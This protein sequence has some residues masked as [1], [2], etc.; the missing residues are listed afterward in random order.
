M[1]K[2]IG[3]MERF[4]WTITSKRNLRIPKDTR[5]L[6][7]FNDNQYSISCFSQMVSKTK[8]INMLLKIRNDVGLLA[9]YVG[10]NKVASRYNV[11]RGFV[12]YWKKKIKTPSFHSG[13]L[14]GARNYKFSADL[15]IAIENLIWS[16]VSND[17]TN[18]IL[19]YVFRIKHLLRVT[20][21][22]NYVERIFRKWRWSWKILDVRKME[23]YSQVYYSYPLC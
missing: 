1:R 10:V 15:R 4:N 7:P 23:K 16:E 5:I 12:R 2:M 3:L 21:S 19:F 6:F 9:Q 20:V 14:G 13:E 11:S 17:P 22:R 18:T 8:S